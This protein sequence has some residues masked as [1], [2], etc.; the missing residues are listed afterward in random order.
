MKQ[1]GGNKD[2]VSSSRSTVPNFQQRNASLWPVP[3]SSGYGADCRVQNVPAWL[4]YSRGGIS[5]SCA[6][7]ASASHCP[8]PSPP[9]S[10]C[11]WMHCFTFTMLPK[12][13]SSDLPIS[14]SSLLQRF[15]RFWDCSALQS[16]GIPQTVKGNILPL[17]SGLWEIS[18][19]Q[20]SN[21]CVPNYMALQ[22]ENCMY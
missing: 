3:I 16:S 1:G 7:R 10:L 21:R 19:N 20:A 12:S 4:H 2:M 17:A 6:H 22:L 14:S 9:S 5:R 18:S 8:K 13:M 15:I 11:C